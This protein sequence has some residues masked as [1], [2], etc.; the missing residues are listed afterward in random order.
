MI[1]QLREHIESKIRRKN[2]FKGAGPAGERYEHYHTIANDPQAVSSLANNLI[3][4]VLG[5]TTQ[6]TINALT[7]ARVIPLLKPN[8]KIRPHAD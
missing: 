6:D 5:H 2:K 4:L 7:S 1:T 3:H 8:G